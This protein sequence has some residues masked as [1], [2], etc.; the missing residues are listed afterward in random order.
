[1]I[2]TAG[3]GIFATSQIALRTQLHRA[4]AFCAPHCGI[5]L[6]TDPIVGWGTGKDGTFAVD[7]T[8]KG[9][10]D[11]SVFGRAGPEGNRS[12]GD[13]LG[14]RRARAKGDG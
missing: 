4:G 12:D 8:S 6:M 5:P 1:V 13:C 9:Q 2:Y 10:W 3:L 14:D 7:E 11:I